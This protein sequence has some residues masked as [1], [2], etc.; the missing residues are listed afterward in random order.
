M[1]K[2]EEYQRAIEEIQHDQSFAWSLWRIVEETIHLRNQRG[3]DEGSKITDLADAES[4]LQILTTEVQ[5]SISFSALES[6]SDHDTNDDWSVKS[7]Y[8]S[9]HGIPEETE[10]EALEQT[11]LAKVEIEIQ[12]PQVDVETDILTLLEEA[13]STY[14]HR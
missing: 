7:N 12:I 2:L 9:I 8:R 14:Q 13:K 6:G 1:R 11:L 5:D 4:K 10:E 3:S